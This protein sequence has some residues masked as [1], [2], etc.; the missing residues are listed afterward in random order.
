M[1]LSHWFAGCAIASSFFVCSGLRAQG[2]AVALT[3]SPT[4]EDQDR[5]QVGLGWPDLR[6]RCNVWGPL[7]LEAKVAAGQGELAYAGRLYWRACHFGPVALVLGGELGGL[8]YSSVDTLDGDGDYYGPFA[9]LQYGFIKRWA[10]LVDYGPAWIHVDSKGNSL[11][12]QQWI[13]NTALYF[14]IF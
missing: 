12:E 11:T 4:T 5:L 2:S 7:D 10:L 3:T 13:L 1:R 8:N 9:G 6:L 14:A